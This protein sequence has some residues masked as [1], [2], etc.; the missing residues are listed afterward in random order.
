M[1]KFEFLQAMLS[2]KGL[3]EENK[4]EKAIELI[5]ELVL[6]AKRDSSEEIIK[7]TIYT[8]DEIKEKVAPIAKKYNIEKVY[9]FGSYARGDADENSDVDLLLDYKRLSGG[10]FAYCGVYVDFEECF[11]KSVDMVSQSAIEQNRN[12]NDAY[13][14]FYNNVMKDRVLIYG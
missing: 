3:L 7:P 5:D 8:I 1:A 14:S 12:K 13:M 6:E 9:L 2:L 11:E 4:V 10:S